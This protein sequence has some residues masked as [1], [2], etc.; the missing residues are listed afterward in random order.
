[1]TNRRGTGRLPHSIVLSAVAALGI[2][3]ALPLVAQEIRVAPGMI[4]DRRTTGKFFGG[5]EVELKLSGDDLDGVR[6]S[7]A[8]LA[9]ALDASGRDLLPAERK[10][11]DYSRSGRGSS[12]GMKLSLKNPARGATALGELSGEVQLF[13]PGRDPAATAVIDKLLSKVDKSL[14]SPA[15]KSA[16]IEARLISPKAYREKAKKAEAEMEKEMAKHREEMKKEAAANGLTDKQAEGLMELAKGLMGMM[17]TVGDND[18]I[19][20]IKDKEKRLFDMEV[21]G[22]DGTAIDS[23]GS[24]SSGEL[25]ILNFSA[26]LPPD[27]RLKFYLLTKKA[28]VSVPFSLKEVPLP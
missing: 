4:E 19:F 22:K 27:A 3:T 12:S 13:V 20:E 24:M 10:E 11:P 5:L 9:K 21:V 8:I 26:K 16:Q 2:G 15:L 6:G 25:K 23:N 28:V 18:L 1:M 7:R 14:S 17:G